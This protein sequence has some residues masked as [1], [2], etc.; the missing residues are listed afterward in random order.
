[1]DYLPTK[2]LVLVDDLSILESTG[3]EIEEQAVKL[4]SE[5]IAEGTLA[6]DFPVPYISW[7][8]LADD[9]AKSCLSGTGTL[10]CWGIHR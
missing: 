8:E 9:S 6:D 4:R 7:S 3:S 5:S 10:D 2:A 1:M